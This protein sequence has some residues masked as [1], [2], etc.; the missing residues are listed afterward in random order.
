MPDQLSI[1]GRIRIPY[2]YT[3][4]KGESEV[5]AFH[6]MGIVVIRNIVLPS[7]GILV[8][9]AAKYGGLVELDPFYEFTLM[10]QY[11]IPP[12]MNIGTVE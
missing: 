8:V 12:A 1:S 5:G 3:G 7:C 9:K 10:L 11:A 2:T 6:I 4:L